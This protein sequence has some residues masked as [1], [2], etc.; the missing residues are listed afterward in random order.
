MSREKQSNITQGRGMKCRRPARVE[1]RPLYSGVLG[2]RLCELCGHQSMSHSSH[3][4]HMKK[5]TPVVKPFKCD[6]CPYTFAAE[7]QLKLH[8]R[9]HTGEKPFQCAYCGRTFRSD[10]GRKVH[11]RQHT[12]EKPFTCDYCDRRFVV[13]AKKKI[14]ERTHTGERPFLCRICGK[15]FI[16]SGERNRCQKA[17]M[18][19]KRIR[20]PHP[21]PRNI[22]QV[23]LGQ[24]LP[25][26][27]TKPR[28]MEDGHPVQNLS[29]EHTM[30][31]H[32]PNIYVP[33]VQYLPPGPS[34]YS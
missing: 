26:E 8:T 7:Y 30:Q 33:P 4:Y 28:S 15:S 27:Q 34:S 25:Y 1:P 10:N 12:G 18:G 9:T 29:Y 13:K 22:E 31:V 21:K 20:R 24:S 14:H 6:Y 3:V 23:N 16:D 17:H 5:H 11:E 2:S 32:F 19:I